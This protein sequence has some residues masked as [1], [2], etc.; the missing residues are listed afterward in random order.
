MNLRLF[1]GDA[2]CLVRIPH[3]R[4]RRDLLEG[5]DVEGVDVGVVGW[6]RVGKRKALDDVKANDV[7]KF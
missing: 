7:Y 3:H 5:R 2:E 1:A 4:R 6:H